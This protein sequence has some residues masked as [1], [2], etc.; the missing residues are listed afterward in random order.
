[1]EKVIARLEDIIADLGF[2]GTSCAGTDIQLRLKEAERYCRELDMSLGEKLCRMLS[3]A[4]SDGN[5]DSAAD[6][7]C[8]LSCYTQC[9]IGVSSGEE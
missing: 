4:L 8:R 2:S 5:T 9:L 1:M 3:E 7:L 6:C